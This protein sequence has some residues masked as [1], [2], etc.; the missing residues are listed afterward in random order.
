MN[1]HYAIPIY[2][3]Q[4]IKFTHDNN[5]DKNYNVGYVFIENNICPS[6]VYNA[7]PTSQFARAKSQYITAVASW[8]RTNNGSK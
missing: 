5:V 7:S 1:F 4:F 2:V 3:L 6:A 8:A